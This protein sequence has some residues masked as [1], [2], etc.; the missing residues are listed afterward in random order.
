MKLS[1]IFFFLLVC[2][3][4]Q[5][6]S[7]CGGTESLN[8]LNPLSQVT[9]QTWSFVNEN[10]D[11]ATAVMNGGAGTANS[12]RVTYPGGG[13]EMKFGVQFS[14]SSVRLLTFA[15]VTG[16][17]TGGVQVV[18][19][20]TGTANGNFGTATQANGTVTLN[21]QAPNMPATSGTG[22]WTA[23]RVN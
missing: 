13:F 3:L 5:F 10:G 15:P 23:V 21:Y 12:W 20:G 19:T 9:T 18:G 1:N 4:I 16:S 14:G 6:I 22:R 8:I 2:C 7:G 17:N 11:T